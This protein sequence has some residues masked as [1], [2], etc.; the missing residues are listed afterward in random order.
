MD[1]NDKAASKSAKQQEKAERRLEKKQEKARRKAAKNRKKYMKLRKNHTWAT[2]LVFFLI[3]L[4]SLG[5]IT[6]FA[7][8]FTGFAVN[9]NIESEYEAKQM[10]VDIYESGVTS[11]DYTFFDEAEMDYIIRDKDGNIIHSKGENTCG[12][13]GRYYELPHAENE[14]RKTVLMYPDTHYSI[15][16]PDD[17]GGVDD[18]D[19]V[20]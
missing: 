8:V 6:V 13:E 5:V 7:S 20:N 15:I 9:A 11:G 4:M 1:N 3:T 18:D 17:D 19:E 14:E 16:E 2:V 10:L 12:R